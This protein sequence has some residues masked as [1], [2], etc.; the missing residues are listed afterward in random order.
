MTKRMV[1]MLLVVG[2]LFGAIFGF[3]AFKARMIKQFMAT[4]KMPPATVTAM[5]AELQPWQPQ[6]NAVGS[7]RA[8]HGVDVTTEIGGLVREIHFKSGDE[9][10]AGQVLV[11]LNADADV[12]QLR[13]LEAAAELARLVYER[14]KEQFAIQAVSQA[15]LDADAADLKSKE[16]K[17]VEQK[18]VVDKK[19]IRAMFDGRL[20]INAVNLGQYVNPG[21]KI[22]TLQSLDPI[23]VDFSLPQQ[24]LSRMKIGQTVMVTTDAI[25]GRTFEGRI[26]AINPKVDPDTRN[27]QAEATIPNPKHELLP[28]MYASVTVRSGE[29]QQYLT[30]PQT[31]VTFN[32]YGES[33]YVI[34]E[35]EKGADGKPVLTAKQTFVTVGETR[36]D[37]VAIVKGIKPGDMVA[38][39]G[40]LKLKNGS[41]VVINNTV[42]PSN[43]PA[44]KPQE[45]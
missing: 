28:G 15:V 22:V 4:M 40:Q 20:G 41:A 34:E 31:A 25:P 17:V 29:V 23:Y 27:L 38:T 11:Q 42:Q 1:I 30:L 9:A 39:S 44:P 6:L 19:T 24:N 16:A 8:V 10:K 36:G 7:L 13:S 18:A 3:Q 21:D 14:D 2:L 43:E 32:P 45:Q 35:G 12:G 5:K 37:Q 26:T 33:V